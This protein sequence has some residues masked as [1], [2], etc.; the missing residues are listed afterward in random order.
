MPGVSNNVQIGQ[1]NTFFSTC[2]TVTNVNFALKILKFGSGEDI[3]ELLA[4]V[5]MK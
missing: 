3:L 1:M 5:E 4:F 2:G